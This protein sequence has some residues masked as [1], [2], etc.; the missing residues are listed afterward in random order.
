MLPTYDRILI[1]FGTAINRFAIAVENLIVLTK[2]MDLEKGENG[3]HYHFKQGE[4]LLFQPK[5]MLGNGRFGQVDK[6]LSTI[7]LKEHARKRVSRIEAFRD[8]GKE[9]MKQF[10]A[11]IQLLKRLKHHN[12]VGFV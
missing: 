10:V 9:H 8:L 3:K 12:V 11:G 4:P 1:A 5:G 6:V 7:G 2:S